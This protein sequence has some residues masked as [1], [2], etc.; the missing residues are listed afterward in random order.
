MQIRIEL[1]NDDGVVVESESFDT[2]GFDYMN[3]IATLSSLLDCRKKRL[4]SSADRHLKELIGTLS[5]I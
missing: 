4:Y 5:D 1:K 2:F 3:F